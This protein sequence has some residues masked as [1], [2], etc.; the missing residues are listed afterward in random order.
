MQVSFGLVR[1]VESKSKEHDNQDEMPYDEIPHFAVERH[2]VAI[3]VEEEFC[4]LGKL[5]DFLTEFNSFFTC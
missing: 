1:E 3:R 5:A 2:G 4:I